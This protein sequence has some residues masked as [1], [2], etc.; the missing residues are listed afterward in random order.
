MKHVPAL[1]PLLCSTLIFGPSIG[2]GLMSGPGSGPAHERGR[3]ELRR[4]QS[5]AA[6]PRYG[7]CWARAL[8]HL[9]TRCKDMTSE[10]QSRLALRF[11]H[12]HLSRKPTQGG[13]DDVLV[14]S[15]GDSY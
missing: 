2:S 8:E 9:D 11:T 7:E 3:I 4:V 6:Q 15:S 14:T 1:L 12:C 10:S 13:H 5:L